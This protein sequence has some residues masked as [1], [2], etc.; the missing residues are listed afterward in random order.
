MSH[1]DQDRSRLSTLTV[2]RFW[3]PLAASW[4]LMSAEMPLVTAFIARMP[5]A[6]LNLAAFGVAFSLVLV[7]ESPIIAMLTAG[8]ALARDRSSYLLVRRFMLGLSA[9]LT[10]VVLLLGYTPL[11]GLVVTRILGV[12]VEVAALVRP[13]LWVMI[14]W[15]AAIAYRRFHQGLMI[16]QG[17]TRRISYGT[18]LRLSTT[19]VVSL[20]G[21]SSG[22]LNGAT[23]AGLALC[24][25]VLAEALYAHLAASPAV[26]QVGRT[27]VYEESEALCLAGLLRFYSPLALTAIV[28]LSTTPVLNFGMIRAPWPIE[29]L[30]VWPVVNGQLFILRSFGYSF[31]EA[32]VALLKGP[33]ALRTLRRFAAMLAGGALALSLALAFT[34]LG[35]WWQQR[36]AGLSAELVVFALPALRW[37]VLLP[38]LAVVQSWLR[39]L[40][41]A[42]KATAAIAWATAI[43]LV[44]LVGV[45][46]VGARFGWLPGAS[47]AAIA[48]VSSQSIE[49][50]WLWVS[51]RPVRLSGGRPAVVEPKAG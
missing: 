36:I 2:L 40:I 25:S 3:A 5:D 24:C 31:Q 50:I 30:A 38:A 39:G 43:N 45:L 27:S 46:L 16:G 6:K 7:A 20:I 14:P 17:Y 32:V 1:P 19:L 9:F 48:L 49:T 12:P 15:P 10:L 51:S 47:L 33:A 23:V 29:S 21:Y 26:E 37:A 18:A 42:G 34:P 22:R 41:I 28:L 13:V 11:F 8:N 4:L 44:S 35:L